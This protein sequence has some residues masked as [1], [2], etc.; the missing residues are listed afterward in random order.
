MR[1]GPLR[2]ALGVLGCC[3]PS[4]EQRGP[5]PQQ[6]RL[7]LQHHGHRGARLA[8]LEASVKLTHEYVFIMEAPAHQTEPACS[9]LGGEASPGSQGA[10]VQRMKE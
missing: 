3:R 5:S 1:P 9:G 8:T 7:A 4:W 2:G 10:S 6:A